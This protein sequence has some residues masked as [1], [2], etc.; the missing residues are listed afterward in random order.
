MTK[1]TIPYSGWGARN[2][3]QVSGED[4][5]LSTLLIMF[6][7]HHGDEDLVLKNNVVG[8]RSHSIDSAYPNFEM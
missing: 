3:A 1:G 6:Y 8:L 4:L 2:R 5:P 7:D